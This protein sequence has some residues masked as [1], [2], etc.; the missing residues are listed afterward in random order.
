MSTPTS[1]TCH[2]CSSTLTRLGSYT[3]LMI[4]LGV[5]SLTLTPLP[6]FGGSSSSS[7]RVA[8]NGPTGIAK[9]VSKASPKLATVYHDPDTNVRNG[10][11]DFRFYLR[12]ILSDIVDAYNRGLD[13]FGRWTRKDGKAIFITGIPPPGKSQPKLDLCC[14]KQFLVSTTDMK[15]A[16]P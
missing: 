1:L 9:A 11:R 10:W 14:W 5:S 7:S 6:S 12:N 13:T 8:N 3:S 2:T 15:V 16:L 4:P